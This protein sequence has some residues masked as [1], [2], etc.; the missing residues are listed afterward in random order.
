MIINTDHRG[1]TARGK[2]TYQPL[3]QL[4]P[5]DFDPN[6]KWWEWATQN[7]IDELIE[8]KDADWTEKWFDAFYPEGTEKTWR[9]IAEAAQQKVHELSLSPLEAQS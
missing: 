2:Y 4:E 5:N 8:L 3:I 7:A 9:E 1:R 6:C